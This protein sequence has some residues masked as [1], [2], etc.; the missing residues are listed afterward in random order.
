[1]TREKWEQILFAH[2]S[3]KVIQNM[4]NEY[5]FELESKNKKLMDENTQLRKVVNAA[6]GCVNRS[7]SCSDC[8]IVCGGCTLQSSIR[9]IDNIKSPCSSVG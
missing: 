6:W 5:V 4:L 7:I 2:V 1:M 8:R 9:A 3:D